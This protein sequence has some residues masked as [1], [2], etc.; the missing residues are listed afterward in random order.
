MGQFLAGMEQGMLPVQGAGVE[1]EE[2]SAQPAA[3]GGGAAPHHSRGWD[4]KRRHV[5]L[6]AFGHSTPTSDPIVSRA[7]L[8]PPPG[9]PCTQQGPQHHVVPAKADDYEGSTRARVQA[10]RVPLVYT[11]ARHVVCRYGASSVCYTRVCVSPECATWH[12]PSR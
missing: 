11:G 10:A 1:G 6:H 2:R 5:R 8:P 4:R 3:C 12:G 7:R 9:L